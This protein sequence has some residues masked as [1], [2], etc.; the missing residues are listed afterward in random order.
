MNQNTEAVFTQAKPIWLKNKRN[1][2]NLQAGFRCDFCA[3]EKK[4][5]VLRVTGATYYRVF[6]NGVFAGYG[7]ARAGHGYL[8][9]DEIVLP[10]QEG[11]NYLAIEVSGE[12]CTSFYTL[13]HTSFLCAEVYEDG[14][15]I[16]WTGRDFQG[17][18]LEKLRNIFC[19]RYSYQRGFG[20]VWNFDKADPLTHWTTAD[21]LSY[22]AL[23]EFLVEETYIPRET[24]LPDYKI[25][26]SEAVA[27][28]GKRIPRDFGE[29]KLPRYMTQLSAMHSDGYAVEE[30]T[31]N[32][33][34]ELYGDFC[35][36][37]TV[38]KMQGD[39]YCIEKGEYVIFKLPFNN[40]GFLKNQIQALEDSKV[41]VFFA[42]Y[43][44]GDG[45]VFCGLEGQTNII[46]YN[47]KKNDEAYELE[48]FEPYVCHYIGIAVAEGKVLAALPQM[49]EY[50]YPEYENTILETADQE[51]KKIMDAATNTFRQN[52]L[53]VFMDCPGRERAGWLCDS[54]FTAQ[55]EKLFT[56]KNTVEKAFL[57]NFVMAKEFPNAPVGMLPHNYPSGIAEYNGGYIPQWA[58]W[59]VVELG[60]YCRERTGAAAKEYQ[61]LCYELL[62]W[63]KKYE[64]EYGLLEHM[65]GWNFVEWSKAN[66]WTQDVNYPTNMLYSKVLSVMA[67]L[68]E[69]EVL[70]EQSEKL[71]Q[72]IIEQSF[73][74]S[75]FVDNAVRNEAGELIR[76]ENRSETCQYYA[77]FFGIA[78]EKDAR[79]AKLTEILIHVFGPDREK[80]G[81]LM[82]IAPA[83][84]FIGNYLRIIILLRMKQF[85]KV[86]QDIRGYFSIMADTTGTLWEHNKLEAGYSGGSLNHGFASYAGAA[87][88]MAL[89]GI[90][91]LDYVNC[92]VELDSDYC[93]GIDYQIMIGTPQG[94]I[95]IA[96]ENGIKTVNL[97]QAWQIK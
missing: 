3:K 93:A 56:G 69:D 41:L 24:L 4:L 14:E 73:D 89:C 5:Y 15:A 23:S 29:L 31:E 44:R 65:P 40:T 50:S 54:Y 90:S 84:A 39:A 34:A 6:L 27:E 78:N 68:F 38:G 95:K 19:Q 88:S 26:Q 83:N 30:W 37:E 58:M 28:R 10:V 1:V 59:F 92:I 79:F 71:K 76:T 18:S 80:T 13:P 12:N 87:L 60:E 43:N 48:S 49:R 21:G 97:P 66:D 62:G 82:E 20:E 22:E 42:E 96:E 17:L 7:P 33:L 67:D 51:L 86:L 36:D 32:P 46:S 91:R 52:T 11:C 47:L 16:C 64:N 77:Y 45:M 61:T 75:F 8:K 55:S 63:F 72:T 2:K 94:E 81:E 53:D 85:Q 35:P 70:R 57:E 25:V 9:Y 74:G